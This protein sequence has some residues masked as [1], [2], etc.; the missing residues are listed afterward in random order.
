MKTAYIDCFSGI[1]G[2]MFLAAMIDAGLDLEYL[3]KELKKLN[4]TGYEITAKKHKK[5]TSQ[6]PN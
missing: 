6:P 1:S 5:T 3:K 2:D 4:L